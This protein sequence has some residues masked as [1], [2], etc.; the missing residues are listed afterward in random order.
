MRD[1]IEKGSSPGSIE[2]RQQLS[3]KASVACGK[4]GLILFT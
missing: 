1:F 3:R 4:S 2:G